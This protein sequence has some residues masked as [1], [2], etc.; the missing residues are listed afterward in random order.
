MMISQEMS[1]AENF[2]KVEKLE[3][4]EI[5]T[6]LAADMLLL[7]RLVSQ[8]EFCTINETTVDS[9]FKLRECGFRNEFNS[10]P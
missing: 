6:E 9:L 5:I 4:P 10:Q 2:N 8:S 7:A 3:T 1:G